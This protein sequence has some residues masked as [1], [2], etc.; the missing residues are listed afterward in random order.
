[1]GK[2]SGQ[3]NRNANIL[4]IMKD[5]QF[6]PKTRFFFFFFFLFYFFFFIEIRQSYR[7]CYGGQYC[8]WKWSASSSSRGIILNIFFFGSK[9]MAKKVVKF[10]CVRGFLRKS[11][12]I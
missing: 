8:L 5:R 6:D 11:R 1:M 4:S 9:V 2:K 3:N 7:K 12:E 10:G